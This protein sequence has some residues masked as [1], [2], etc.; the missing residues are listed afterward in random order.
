MPA[1]SFGS[2]AGVLAG[3]NL[4]AG[5]PERAEK[6]AWVAVWLLE[7]FIGLVI[8]ILLLWV[9]PIVG[10]FTDDISLKATSIQ[11]IQIAM[12][13]WTMIGFM[14]VLMNCLQGAGDTIA[15]MII[16]V[17][18]TW[19]ITI[20]PAYLLPKYTSWGVL[21]IR[22]AITASVLFGGIA[23]IIYFRTGRWKNRKI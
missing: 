18:D 22:W 15:T 9:G 7:G 23:M 2:G 5:K 17:V 13:G 1:M 4:G 12:V 21:G 16:G 20:L 11:Y 10:I 3:Q 19:L 14:F 8:V 6:S